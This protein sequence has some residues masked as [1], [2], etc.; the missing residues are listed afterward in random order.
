MVTNKTREYYVAKHLLQYRYNRIPTK[1]LLLDSMKE[2]TQDYRCE[3]HKIF[4]E[5]KSFLLENMKSLDDYN[6]LSA[7][8]FEHLRKIT[9]RSKDNTYGSYEILNDEEN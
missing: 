5:I 7:L 4:N 1:E 8:K 9:K 6:W 2:A 3:P